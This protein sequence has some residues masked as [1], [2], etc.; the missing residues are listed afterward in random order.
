ML[1]RQQILE[2]VA[3]HLFAQGRASIKVDQDQE[4]YCVYRGK[5]GLKCAAGV[6]IPDEAYSPHMEKKTVDSFRRH[7][8]RRYFPDVDPDDVG[9]LRG[10]QEI[11]D[12]LGLRISVVF[13]EDELRRRLREYA[14]EFELDASFLDTLHIQKEG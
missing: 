1:T 14:E 9:F 13:K 2:T 11:H 12:R 6:L 5:D 8:F 4:P 7:S 3:R 10:L